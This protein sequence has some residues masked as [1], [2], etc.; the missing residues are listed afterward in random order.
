MT[1]EQLNIHLQEFIE[2]ELEG[3]ISQLSACLA[4]KRT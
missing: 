2:V 1:I 4:S 3:K